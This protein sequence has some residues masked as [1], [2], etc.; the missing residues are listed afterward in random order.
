MAL[1]EGN[2]FY[3]VE[4]DAP[5]RICG[6][7]H[8]YVTKGCTLQVYSDFT[9]AAVLARRTGGIVRPIERVPDGVEYTLVTLVEGRPDA[10]IPAGKTSLS[11]R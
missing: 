9:T 7:E 11:R 8:G 3:V 5:C 2:Y 6:E 10:S 1:A 4:T